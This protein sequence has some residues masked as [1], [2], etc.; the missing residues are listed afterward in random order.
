M[1]TYMKASLWKSNSTNGLLVVMEGSF[2]V[3]TPNER[4]VREESLT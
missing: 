3:G 4:L 2:D 1:S